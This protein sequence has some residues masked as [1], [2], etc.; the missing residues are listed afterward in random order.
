MNV[1]MSSI[2]R[3]R[4]PF[5][6]ADPFDAL[7][8]RTHPRVEALQEMRPSSEYYL[9]SL[10]D[11]ILGT[12]WDRERHELLRVATSAPIVEQQ[13]AV[14]RDRQERKPRAPEAR[15]LTRRDLAPTRQAYQ[16]HATTGVL[17]GR[18]S[19]PLAADTDDLALFAC[20]NI[21]KAFALTS[22]SRPMPG[23]QRPR[24]RLVHPIDV[25]EVRA[26]TLVVLIAAR[27][28]THVRGL[29]GAEMLPEPRSALECPC[30][31]LTMRL[32]QTRQFV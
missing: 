21:L 17:L 26:R 23:A 25:P 30:N 5:R 16:S 9:D 1:R 6:V 22:S 4:L 32:R 13:S 19:A 10:L 3:S 27:E 15:A 20:A 18:A 2:I 24:C 29:Y 11:R 28:S 14:A 7:L 8:A 31:A 12:M